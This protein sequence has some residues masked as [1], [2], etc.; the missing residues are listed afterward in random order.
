MALTPGSAAAFATLIDLMR[1]WGWGLRNIL[2]I[3]I[4]GIEKSAAKAARPVTLSSPSGLMVRLPI[5]LLSEPFT[6]PSAV[7]AA[8]PFR[9]AAIWRC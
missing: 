4:P 1:A 8:V 9:S 2:A 6:E 3:N 5:H 7:I